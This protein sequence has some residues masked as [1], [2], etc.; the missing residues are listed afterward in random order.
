MLKP[1]GQDSR[2]TIVV[3]HSRK[4]QMLSLTV[5]HAETCWLLYE[6]NSSIRFVF[7]VPISLLVWRLLGF[8]LRAV[9]L[10][11]PVDEPFL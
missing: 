5:V 10:L 6:V 4:R 3:D 9:C 8:W 11:T 7:V 2:P 1:V